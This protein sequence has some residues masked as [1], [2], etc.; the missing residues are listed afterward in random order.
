MTS[1]GRV[2]A[3]DSIEIELQNE[4]AGKQSAD[5]EGHN[6]QSFKYLCKEYLL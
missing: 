1:L 5:N 2:C 4:K 6:D 3:D